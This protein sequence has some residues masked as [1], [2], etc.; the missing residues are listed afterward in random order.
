[1]F[2]PLFSEALFTITTARPHHQH[3]VSV[4]L[5]SQQLWM[6]GGHKQ[7]PSEGLVVPSRSICRQTSSSLTTLDL[8]THHLFLRWLKP[9]A[10]VVDK[11]L[12]F[13]KSALDQMDWIEKITDVAMV[14]ANQAK[15]FNNQYGKRQ[16]M[17]IGFLP[18]TKSWTKV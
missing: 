16:M 10:F 14:Q 13:T 17:Q 6:R 7:T 4:V 11:K 12:H 9:L 1:M 15:H 8:S 5:Q 2:L 3:K 18:R